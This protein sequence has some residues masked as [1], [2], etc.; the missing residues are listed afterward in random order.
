MK[1][2]KIAGVVILVLVVIIGGL[3][4]VN[5]KPLTKDEAVTQIQKIIKNGLNTKKSVYSLLVLVDAPQKDINLKYAVGISKGQSIQTDQ[6]FHVASVGKLFTATLIGHLVDQGKLNLNDPIN[7]YLEKS[8]LENLFVY[9]GVDYQDKVTINHLLSHSSGVAD[10]FALEDNGLM[11]TLY[12]TPDKFYTPQELVQYTREHQSAYFAPGEGYHYSDTGYILLGLIIES[13]TGKSFH[14]NLHEVIFDPLEM[15]DTFLL[16]YSEPLNGKRPIAEAWVNG[17]EVSENQ[18]VSIDWAGGGVVST[19]DDLAIYIRA[20]YQGKLIS[21][22]TLD[23][24]NKFDYEFMRGIAYGYGF[25]QMQFEKFMP[26]LGFLPRM[27][28]HM[29]VLGTQLFY[30]RETDMVYVSSFGS[31]DATAASVQTMIQIL[32]TIYRIK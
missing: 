5:T 4:W 18:S 27:S 1:G 14:K 19:L 28:G 10:Y 24:M 32:S 8:M 2:L 7:L 3:L 17:H 30:N 20:L 31:T 16:F 11:E 13:I 26:T 29:G 9:Q 25:M 23:A 21:L 6:P 12:Q 22:Q 15:K